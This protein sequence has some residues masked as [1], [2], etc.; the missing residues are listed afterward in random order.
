V[1]AGVRTG[2]PAA[3]AVVSVARD[4]AYAAHHHLA[5]IL[6]SDTRTT[7]RLAGSGRTQVMRGSITEYTAKAAHRGPRTGE[8]HDPLVHLVHN[9]FPSLKSNSEGAGAIPGLNGANGTRQTVSAR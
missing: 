5:D 1:N 4:L 6:A 3:S 2:R 8:N 7:Q 9:G